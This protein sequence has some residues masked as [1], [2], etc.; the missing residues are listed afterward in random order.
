M[1]Y[2]GDVKE[3][4]TEEVENMKKELNRVKEGSG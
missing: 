4:F 3:A 2:Q 1:K